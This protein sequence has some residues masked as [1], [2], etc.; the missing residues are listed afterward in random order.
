MVEGAGP[1]AD[2]TPSNLTPKIMSG[3]I[4][5]QRGVAWEREVAKRLSEATGLEFRRNVTENQLGNR[6][7]IVVPDTI[8]LA[9]QCKA[10]ARPP[11][12]QALEEANEVAGAGVYPVAVLKRMN[13]RGRPCDEIVVMRFDDFLE[14]LESLIYA[15]VLGVLGSDKRRV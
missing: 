9:I 5:R 2:R 13:G 7:D 10:G 14:I 4:S 11:V 6:G 8:P 3:R 12:F 1:T 15:N